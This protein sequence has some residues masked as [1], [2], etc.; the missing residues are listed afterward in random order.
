MAGWPHW[1]NGHVAVGV[2]SLFSHVR[3]CNPMDNSPTRLLSPW[4]FPGKNTGAGCHFFLQGIF[5]SQG[6]NL[7]LLQHRQIL[8]H[9]SQ[10]SPSMD[11]NLSKLREIVKDREALPA[12]VHRVT[13]SQTQL[14]DWTTTINWYITTALYSTFLDFKKL[15]LTVWITV[16]C[17]KFWK[18]RE[19]QTT[20]PASWETCMQVRK[21]QLELDMEQQTGSK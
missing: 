16:N 1:L 12:A 6:L 8:Y 9:L 7:G 19:Y 18:R 3:L 4:N 15:N 10:G 11:M 2:L 21:Q 14:H 17:G 20:W 5:L 13:K